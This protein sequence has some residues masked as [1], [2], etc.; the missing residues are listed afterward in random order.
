MYKK[1]EG[2]LELC[3][4]NLTKLGTNSLYIDEKNDIINKIYN[5]YISLLNDEK[6]Y[7]DNW[8]DGRYKKVLYYI[9]NYQKSVHTRVDFAYDI[10]RWGYRGIISQ[11]IDYM[12]Y[13]V[14]PIIKK[15]INCVNNTY[16]Y[17][18]F[19]Y[20]TAMFHYYRESV[21]K[22]SPNQSIYD[23]TL[24]SLII[25]LDASSLYLQQR[26]YY[27]LT[28]LHSLNGDFEKS[29]I[30][31][32]K[33]ISYDNIPQSHYS[34]IYSIFT[35]YRLEGIFNN[36]VSIFTKDN[37][38]NNY[39]WE[40][41]K[42]NID[43]S[44]LIKNIEFI[45]KFNH[46]KSVDISN[47]NKIIEFAK[48]I[49]LYINRATIN[50]S[51]LQR[52]YNSTIITPKGKAEVL[53]SMGENIRDINRDLNRAM[54][55]FSE[56]IELYRDK[57][58]FIKISNLILNYFSSE[59]REILQNRKGGFISLAL[60]RYCYEQS[61]GKT[62]WIRFVDTGFVSGYFEE[63][64][65]FLEYIKNNSS[66]KDLIKLID[67]RLAFL[68][69]KGHAGVRI[70][71]YNQPNYHK[72]QALFEGVKDN[73]LVTKYLNH[74]ILSIYN[75]LE[76]IKDNEHYLYF[77]NKKSDELLILF[78]CAFSY[79]HYTQLRTFY[80][81]N[82]I[83]VLFL[84][85]PKL[86]W[87][88]GDEWNRVTKTIERVSEGF[89]RQ[90]IICY[91]GSMGGY[92]AL[93]VGLTYGFKSIVFNPQI[94]MNIWIK[95]RPILAPRLLEEKSLTNIQDFD[96]T[97]FEKSPIY[98][99][100]SSS[101]EDVEVFEIFIQ[102]ISL[103]K[104][105]LFIFEKIPNNTHAGIF[106]MIYKDLQQDVIL[107]ISKLQDR[108]FPSGNY[109]RLDYKISDKEQNQFWSFLTNALS[110]RV[111]IQIV[112]GEIYVAKIKNNFSKM[113]ELSKLDVESNI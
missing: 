22:N 78:S 44:I 31:Y 30:G 34:L 2:L 23:K 24:N 35:S 37:I 98:Y 111:I 76:I 45:M 93:K 61:M 110:L 51:L 53:F 29:V 11:D 79:A 97:A 19:A 43:S 28:Q 48:T 80:K 26:S 15:E 66:N 90:K 10:F 52:L 82:R 4:D 9:K 100:T 81:K 63:E 46:Y 65:E 103:V 62:A 112:N 59:I 70:H 91:F 86:N 113:I 7:I 60:N 105:G 50:I 32:Y 49:S 16:D 71:D 83:N 8:L 69:Y 94:D 104:Q 38:V 18:S 1:G 27:F 67:T 20:G 17:A 40:L 54:L 101:I 25:S 95:Y 57:N 73:P 89:K 72:A 88:H 92:M 107:N 74:P 68:Y 42:S 36:I 14:E 75:K 64:V 33:S 3:K 55:M 6:N 12:V 21:Y 77:E 106:G 85:N 5:G 87:Y 47:K 102:K 99:M 108:Y 56:S 84:N 39:F 109:I 96:I 13:L 41:I 58:K